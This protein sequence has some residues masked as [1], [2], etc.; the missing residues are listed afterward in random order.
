MLTTRITCLTCSKIAVTELELNK[1]PYCSSPE[2]QKE[3][4]KRSD[5]PLK[6]V[7]FDKLNS[8]QQQIVLATEGVNYVNAGP[9]TAKSTTLA[10]RAKYIALARRNNLHHPIILTFTKE[11][12][13]HITNILSLSKQDMPLVSTIHSFA[14]RRITKH[15]HTSEQFFDFSFRIMLQDEKKEILQHI[16]K[17]LPQYSWEELAGKITLY[18][19]KYKY[20]DFLLTDM[21]H[22]DPLLDLYLKEQRDL[23]LYDFDDLVNLLAFMI[24]NPDE[25]L[26]GQVEVVLKKIR[27]AVSGQY[28]SFNPANNQYYIDINQTEDFD[29]LIEQRAASLDAE[30]LDQAFYEALKIM[31][32]IQDVPSKVS[33]YHIW[34]FDKVTWLDHKAPRIGYLFFGAPNERSTAQPARDYYIYFLRHFSP[35]RFKNENKSDEVFFR[36]TNLEEGFLKSVRSYAGAYDLWG[37]SSGSKKANYEMKMREHLRA[38]TDWLGKKNTQVFEVTYQGQTKSIANWLIGTDLRQLSGI[39]SD[40]RLS[41]RDMITLISAYLLGNHFASQAPDYPVFKTYIPQTNRATA[42]SDALQVIAGGHSKYGLA[43]L[44]ALQLLDGDQIVTKNSVYAQKVMA[45]FKDRQTG[46]VVNREEMI[47]SV[48]GVEYFDMYSSRLEPDFLVVILAALIYTGEITLTV[49]GKKYDAANVDMLAA[50]DVENL[51]NFKHMEQ[52]KDWNLPGLKALFELVGLQT[53]YASLVTQGK[54]EPVEKLQSTLA[55]LVQQIVVAQ[56]GIRNGLDFMGV[57]LL[58]ICG[59]RSVGNDLTKTKEFLEHMQNFNAPAKLKQFKQS[60][61]E[62]SVYIPNIQ[63][64]SILV[65]LRNFYHENNVFIAYLNSAELNL[66]ADNAW[67]NQLKEIRG[68]IAEQLSKVTDAK[69]VLKILPGI[70]QQLKMLK[71]DYI[72]SYK[73]MHDSAR[74][75]SADELKRNQLQNDPRMKTLLNIAAIEIMPRQKLSDFQNKLSSLRSCNNLTDLQ[76]DS[77]AICPHCQYSPSREGIQGSVSHLLQQLDE[78]LDTM[79]ESW[80]TTLLNDMEDPVAQKNI[81]LLKQEDA[82]AI[83]EFL[84]KREMTD[85]TRLIPALQQ[86][87]NGLKKVSFKLSDVEHALQS[88]GPAKPEELKQRFAEYVDS[89]VR[90]EDPNKI[91]IVLE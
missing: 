15:A 53:G 79:L 36:L 61:E 44:D 80:T 25:D 9:G 4:S 1:C 77:S 33:G 76:L 11:A 58:A 64:L 10:A 91:R 7:Y 19:K 73:K 75:S 29:T 68:T 84:S 86:I 21:P 55:D 14:Y 16:Q 67:V 42:V 31:M 90:G 62:I 56:N 83:K 89:M 48:S 52:P 49:V 27:A 54:N 70:S 51:I 40:Q 85:N 18:K 17:L 50:A 72:V 5:S 35:V 8:D 46:Q 22:S 78:Q 87:L 2:I 65:K 37:I 71:H 6:A 88:A 38:I 66:T 23:E 39:S 20:M 32:E 26:Q 28:I 12:A 74:M 34:Q 82:S 57:D 47:G 59:Y 81:E 13:N 30:K 45:F 24:G 3:S 41:F 60:A 69:S 63:M 43:L